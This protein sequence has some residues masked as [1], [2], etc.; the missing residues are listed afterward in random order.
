[1]FILLRIVSL[2]F[3]NLMKMCWEEMS[4]PYKWNP[5]FPFEI[6]INPIYPGERNFSLSLLPIFFSYSI[7]FFIGILVE[8]VTTNVSCGK[9]LYSTYKRQDFSRSDSRCCLEILF[10]NLLS[11]FIVT[12]IL[13]QTYNEIWS[14]WCLTILVQHF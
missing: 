13:V 7:F 6:I 5:L 4:S 8:N 11:L 2:Q 9:R 14:Y 10:S 12:R 1:M 3:I